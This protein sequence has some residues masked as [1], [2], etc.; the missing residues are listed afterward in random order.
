MRPLDFKSL[1]EEAPGS[2]MVL[3]PNL[4]LVAANDAYLE[5]TA[6]VREAILGRELFE[7]FPELLDAVASEREQGARRRVNA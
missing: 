6:T 4:I 7:V 3:D 1:F 5:E 2:Y